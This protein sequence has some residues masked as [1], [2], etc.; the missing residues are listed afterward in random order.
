MIVDDSKD[1][2]QLS[3]RVFEKIKPGIKIVTASNGQNALQMLNGGAGELPRVILLDIRMPGMDGLEVLSRIKAEKALHSIPVCMFSNGD[4][5]KDIRSAYRG[6]A[7]FYFKK[8]FTL[9]EMYDFADHFV[10]LWFDYA[11]L[12]K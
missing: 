3:L 6:C 12:E 4:L 10:K 7:S 5:E 11:C 2:I 9:N 8:P 1:E